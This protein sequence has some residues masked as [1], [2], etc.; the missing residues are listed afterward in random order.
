MIT[1]GPATIATWI[2]LGTAVVCAII[3]V[4]CAWLVLEEDSQDRP[5][6]FAG[7]I[8]VALLLAGGFV[9]GWWPF[10]P[11]Y[12]HWYKVTG[13][14]SEVS[15]R[16][17]ASGKGMEQRFVLRLAEHA[18]PFA[19]DDTRAALVKKGNAV[20]LACKRSWVYASHSGWACRWAGTS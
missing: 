20:E 13:T 5:K 11:E 19:V 9:W 16:Q 7:V 8:A 2:T 18:E 12:H 15:S 14:V 3:I 10:N 1:Q 17:V 4:I 6:A